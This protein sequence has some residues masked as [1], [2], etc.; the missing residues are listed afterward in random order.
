MCLNK[1]SKGKTAL[2][3]AAAL[4]GSKDLGVL[5]GHTHGAID[6]PDDTGARS[7]ASWSTVNRTG[8]GGWQAALGNCRFAE[9]PFGRWQLTV[10]VGKLGVPLGG[11]QF[12]C[13]GNL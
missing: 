7:C 3:I 4:K 10:A 5:L 1:W 2:H 13:P 6:A 8:V 12:V 9:T 11:S